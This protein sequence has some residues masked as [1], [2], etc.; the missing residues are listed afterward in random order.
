MKFLSNCIIVH[1]PTGSDINSSSIFCTDTGNLLQRMVI[2]PS[3]NF[4]PR[5]R[6]TNRGRRRAPTKEQ[7]F[8]IHCSEETSSL[9][10]FLLLSFLSWRFNELGTRRCLRDISRFAWI[11]R[12]GKNELR[13]ETCCAVKF[14][15]IVVSLT[16]FKMASKI[17]F[18]IVKKTANLG[19]KSVYLF[20]VCSGDNFFLTLCGREIVVIKRENDK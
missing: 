14:V 7:R 11:H 5:S 3:T 16:D 10:L 6:A 8:F 17:V 18:L 15:Q 1:A 12:E 9:R 20:G 19:F 13:H 4:S 2:Q